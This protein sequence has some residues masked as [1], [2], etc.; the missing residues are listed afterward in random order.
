VT[1]NCAWCGE[2]VHEENGS[3]EDRKF[4]KF[5]KLALYFCGD[6]CQKEYVEDTERN[7]GISLYLVVERGE[8]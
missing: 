4:F 8:V 1:K 7:G 6:R 5:G 3:H 2:E